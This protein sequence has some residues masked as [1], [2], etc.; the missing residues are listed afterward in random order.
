RRLTVPADT[1]A[2]QTSV[3]RPIIGVL[4]PSPVEHPSTGERAGQEEK[5]RSPK[6]Q[7]VLTERINEPERP[8]NDASMHRPERPDLLLGG[9]RPL[10]LK[11]VVKPCNIDGGGTGQSPMH[12][13]IPDRI[14]FHTLI[15]ASKSL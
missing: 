7:A 4:N 13:A 14:E 10:E 15:R 6:G 11:R 3:F 5:L 12:T 9:V 2:T 8:R 1:T